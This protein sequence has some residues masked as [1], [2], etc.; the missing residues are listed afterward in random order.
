MDDRFPPSTWLLGRI[1]D[2]YPGPGGLVR[3]VT[4]KTATTALR[5][6]IA[7][8]CPLYVHNGVEKADA[9]ISG[10]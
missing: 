3:V 2:V 5:R 10:G 6:H 1:L 9:P 8:L 4:V 7:R